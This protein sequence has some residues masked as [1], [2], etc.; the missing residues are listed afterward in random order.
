MRSER[1]AEAPFWIKVLF[2]LDELPTQNWVSLRSRSTRATG[3]SIAVVVL[4]KLG[5]ELSHRVIGSALA[6]DGLLV[7]LRSTSIGLLGLVAALG[8][9]LVAFV[10]SQGWPEVLNSP[11]PK[12]PPRVAAVHDAVR[13]GQPS[14]AAA[15]RVAH[16]SGPG[17]QVSRRTE[18][19]AQPPSSQ[20]T[21]LHRA[22]RA[23]AANGASPPPA[24]TPA[25][26][27]P[28]PPPATAPVEQGGGSV[29]V[30]TPASSQPGAKPV[31]SGAGGS[32]GPSSSAG[33][34]KSHGGPKAHQ[35]TPKAHQPTKPSHGHRAEA[36][37]PAAEAPPTESGS[38]DSAEGGSGKGEETHG[39]GHAYGK[40]GKGG[41]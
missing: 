4:S 33:K 11:I 7:R 12:S 29:P 37:P 1:V 21:G 20:G 27:S 28:A 2:W 40:S 24:E 8:L 32:P 34:G 41:D 38:G 15:R 35:P 10:A 16:V 31:S 39:K 25:S 17:F 14:S 26:P 6:G 36:P 3:S 23:H 19:L 22:H 9:A 18:N 13:L 30:S 5:Q